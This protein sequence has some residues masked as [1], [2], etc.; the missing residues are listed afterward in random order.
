MASVTVDAVSLRYP[1]GT[2]G[3]A[4]IDLRIADG[5]SIAL[6]GPSGSGKTTLLRT[7]AGFLTPTAGQIAI[8]GEVVAGTGRPVPPEARGLGMVFQQ[9]AVWPHWNVERNVDYPLRRAGVTRVERRDRVA[10]M[11]ALVG[12][13][14]FAKRDPSTLSGGQRQRVALARALVTRPRVLLLDEALSALD[15]PLRDR[16]RLEL[17]ALTRDFG[18]TVVHVTHDRA[19]ALALADRVIVMDAG[20]VQQVGAPLEV[21]T[22]PASAFVATFLNDATIVRGT[23][24]SDIFRAADHPLVAPVVGGDAISGGLAEA[25]IARHDVRVFADAGGDAVVRSS[26]FTAEGGDL[27]V[28]WAGVRLRVKTSG[29]RP[30]HGDRVR[31]EIAGVHTFRA[32]SASEP[33]TLVSA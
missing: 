10:E 23:V 18:T 21:L 11:L 25:A 31:V 20:R 5:E 12:L 26:L 9:H 2:L 22:A 14:G 30:R 33:S 28:E 8:G 4:D 6:V 16:L 13:N 15:E 1:N 17:H 29:Y 19:E 27:V 32:S 7:I 3:L 24:D